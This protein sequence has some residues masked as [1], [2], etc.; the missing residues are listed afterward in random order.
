MN[1]SINVHRWTAFPSWRPPSWWK[2]PGASWRTAENFKYPSWQQPKLSARIYRAAAH[3]F[4]LLCT[5]M[6]LSRKRQRRRKEEK[7]E[8]K[9]TYICIHKCTYKKETRKRVWL[10]HFVQ[11]S[12]EA[13]LLQFNEIKIA[14]WSLDRKHG[15][16]ATWCLLSFSLSLSPTIFGKNVEGKV[17]QRGF[18][19]S[20]SRRPWYVA[21]SMNHRSQ[22]N[23]R[24]YR[25]Y[26]LALLRRAII[27]RVS[28]HRERKRGGKF[29][30]CRWEGTDI[31]ETGCRSGARLLETRNQRNF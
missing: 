20:R 3:V 5:R 2:K 28:R 8:K 16:K 13:S 29:W 14:S 31:L 19:R 11:L 7:R 9:C 30:P 27:R 15:L 24:I 21:R 18:S 12:F 1:L 6:P 23:L 22:W 25:A 10:I 4:S 26:A 17:G